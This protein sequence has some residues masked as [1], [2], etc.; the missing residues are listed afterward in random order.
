GWFYGDSFTG[1][2][3]TH[4]EYISI[5]R[6]L[7]N[8]KLMCGTSFLGLIFIHGSKLVGFSAVLQLLSHWWF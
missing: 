8:P 1:D 7:N 6:Y 4:L 2:F 3:P 5:F